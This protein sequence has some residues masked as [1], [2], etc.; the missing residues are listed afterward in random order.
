MDVLELIDETFDKDRTETYELSIQV[1]LNG[2]SFAVKDTIR[3][4]FIVL[5]SKP[6]SGGVIT[7][8]NW[9]S[10]VEGIVKE[11]PFLNQKFKKVF[12]S[13]TLSPFT[14]VPEYFF[15]IQR[16]KDLFELTHSLPEHFEL[17]YTLISNGENVVVLFA[18]PYTLSSAW[19]KVQP[20]TIFLTQSS[21]LFVGFGKS[22][23]ENYVQV[24][25][26]E[27]RMTI[28]YHKNEKLIAA[29]TFVYMHTNDALYYI[30]S[31]CN[32]LS[33]NFASIQLSVLGESFNNNELVKGLNK[34]FSNVSIDPIFNSVHFS[35]RLLRQRNRYYALFNSFAVCE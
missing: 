8:D 28:V 23:Y 34:S 20:N 18:M 32:S 26:E 9:Y 27:T 13:Y 35:Y 31:F 19:L 2:F 30:L 3:N 24:Y 25:F 10:L 17:R 5:I 1:S 15:D 29:N 4:T 6:F 33:D 11:F 14:I 22:K 12:F 7:H 21:S 16:I